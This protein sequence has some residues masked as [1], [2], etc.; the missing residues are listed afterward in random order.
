MHRFL[1]FRS[2]LQLTSQFT[3][4]KMSGT[5]QSIAGRK[6]QERASRIPEAWR[7]TASQ[8]DGTASNV[9]DVPRTCG[10]LLDSELKITED[11]DATS[12][13]GE[14]AVGRL[15]SEDVVRAFSKRAAIAQ[16][17]TNC[18]TEILFAD[19]LARAR[20]LDN[21]LAIHGRPIGPLHGLPISLKDTFKI[22]GYDASIGIAGLCF[23][24]ATNNS[25]L[26]DQ[27]LSLGAVL[28][29][30]T[31]VPQT[32]MALDSHNNV[33]G[34]T[35][36]P[37][38]KM[39]TAGGSSG[40][41]GALLAMRGSLIGVGTDVGGSVRIP[42]A[43][44]GLFGVKP[45]HGRVPFA[46]QEGGTKPGSSKLAIEAT[47]GP[48]TTSLRDCELFLRVVADSHP[49]SFDPEVVAQSWER[50]VPLDT[51]KPLR[52]GIVRTDGQ[53]KPLPPI[54]RLLDRVARTLQ[55]SRSSIEVVD[56]DASKILSQILKTFNGIISIDGA[57][58]WFDLLEATQEPLSPWLKGRLTRRPQKSLDEVRKL[59]AQKLELQTAFLEVWKTADANRADS[60]HET[61]DALIMPVAPHPIL[62]IDRWNTVNYTGS[63]NLLDVSTGV[64]PV[65]NFSTNDLDGDVPTSRPINGWDKINREH[66]TQVDRREY[67]GSPLSIQVVTPRL[68]ERKLVEAMTILHGALAPLRQHDGRTESKL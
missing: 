27:L 34:R 19:A 68:T 57:N 9:L 23:K 59:Q 33:F 5:W 31:N 37:A 44:N 66:W 61:L 15:R 50:Q 24:P 20:D 49:E 41:E 32:M 7:L 29:C 62:P 12:L 13:L 42:A 38:N 55:A 63:L 25:A 40:G 3:F 1:P 58:S 51:R 54:E 48:I 2:T 39:L 47:A 22:R 64:L 56:V 11:Y 21:H 17:L 53:T 4:R 65:T 35:L 43:C 28:F 18:L 6:Q 52:V 46:G 14:L 36:N 45:S 60:K 30:K 8:I 26:V 67:V 10:L 16:Q